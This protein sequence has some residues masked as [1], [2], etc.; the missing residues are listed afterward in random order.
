MKSPA[1]HT[2]LALNAPASTPETLASAVV[3]TGASTVVT[4]GASTVVTT[5]ASIVA[6]GA[7][8]LACGASVVVLLALLQPAANN[9]AVPTSSFVFVMSI[10]PR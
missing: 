6:A 8:M 3:T 10:G 2:A 1:I 5:G 7:S 4:T 9:S